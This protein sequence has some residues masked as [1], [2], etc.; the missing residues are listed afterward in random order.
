MD[1]GE[2]L[3]NNSIPILLI[4]FFNNRARGVIPRPNPMD[5]GYEL[6]SRGPATLD[7]DALDNVQLQFCATYKILTLEVI[8]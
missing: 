8:M 2:G 7:H 1:L 5:R 6:C 4:P 3:R